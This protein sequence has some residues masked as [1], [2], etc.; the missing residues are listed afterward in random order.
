[1][2]FSPAIEAATAAVKS[3]K[4]EGADFII[5]ITHLGI[6]R[7][8][9]LARA[10]KG[11]NLILGGHD[12][13]PISFYEGNTL[14]L[15]AGFDAHYLVVADIRIEKRE[16][17]RGVKVTMMPEWRYVST[18]GVEADPDIGAIVAKHA[19]KLDKALDVPVGKTAVELDS[20][21]SNVR[22]RETTMGN[23]IAD[24][25]RAG[26]GAEI[27]FTNGGG[28]RGNRTYDA[29]TTLTRKDVLTELPFGNVTLLIEL[30]GADLLAALEN[31]VSQVEDVKGRFP[32]VSGMSFAFDP[33]AP[34]GS[35]VIEVEVGGKPLDKTR[36][37]RIATND[38]VY[39]GGDGYSALKKG[40]AIID[41]SG[42]TLMATM[43]MDYIAG[44]GSVSPSLEGR[45]RTK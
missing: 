38:Y 2:V 21:R 27:G 6:A 31:G 41:A 37:Y 20:Q 32:Q 24:A 45:I 1:M 35:R 30:S 42:A 5:A 4:D 15:K 11:I 33:K 43:V 39:G 13:D 19:T 22:T 8:R 36:L 26:V 40:K 14:I 3:L 34:K 29:G 25:I 23:L 28:I 44:K 16:T 9:E 17:D 18:A 7:D 10:V 12:H